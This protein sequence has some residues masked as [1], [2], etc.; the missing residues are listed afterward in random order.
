MLKDMRIRIAAG[1]LAGVLSV[2]GSAQV[3]AAV[4]NTRYA[5]DGRQSLVVERDSA[6]ARVNFIDRSYVLRRK[7][8][9]IGVKYESPHA[10]LIIDGSSAVFVADNRLQLGIC[11]AAFP[12]ASVR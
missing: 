1:L 8:S 2:L 3:H 7:S 10:A 11:T 9:S 5:C 4:S 6:R 12:I